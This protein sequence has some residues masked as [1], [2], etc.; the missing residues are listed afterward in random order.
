MTEE[1]SSEGTTQLAVKR[2]KASKRLKDL[3]S[4]FLVT[5]PSSQS[6]S[7]TVTV[8]LF[9]G[10]PLIKTFRG[11]SE[12]DRTRGVWIWAASP[13]DRGQEGT[14]GSEVTGKVRTA[15]VRWVGRF[16]SLMDKRLK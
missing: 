14:Q 9:M 2:G 5:F 16:E 10:S 6:V 13:F 3:F 12:N 15:R 11:V 7:E 1:Q 8:D 4:V